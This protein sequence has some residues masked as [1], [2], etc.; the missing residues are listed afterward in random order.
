MLLKKKKLL[1]FFFEC[2]LH[3]VASVDFWMALSPRDSFFLFKSMQSSYLSLSLL[4]II[5]RTAVS[6]TA[7]DVKVVIQEIKDIVNNDINPNRI[8]Q[9]IDCIKVTSIFF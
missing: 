7:T 6:K 4:F 8:K 1:K 3:L 5:K 2:F 9:D